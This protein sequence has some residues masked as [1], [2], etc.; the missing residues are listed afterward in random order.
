LFAFLRDQIMQASALMKVFHRPPVPTPTGLRSSRRVRR[1]DLSF[2]FAAD[3]RFR[4]AEDASKEKDHAL[5]GEVC[6]M[7]KSLRPPRLR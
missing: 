7:Q 1:D 6:H 3:R 4:H 5:R 2:F